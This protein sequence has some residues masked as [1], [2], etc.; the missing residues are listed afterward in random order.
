MGAFSLVLGRHHRNSDTSDL[1]YSYLL[2]NS[3]ESYLV[4]AINL[5]SVG[6]TRDA[7]KW[8]IR[9]RRKGPK[10]LDHII[11]NL[12]SPYSVQKIIKGIDILNHLKKSA[13]NANGFYT[14]NGV[15]IEEKSLVRGLELYKLGLIKF[16]GNG[17]LKKLEVGNYA[18]EEEMRKALS[19]SA[20][21]GEQSWV[22]MAGLIVPKEKVNQL[23]MSI[24]SGEVSDLG[25]LNSFFSTWKDHYFDW[26]WNWT[27]ARL[28]SEIQLD[29]QTVKV[30]EIIAFVKEWESAVVGLDKMMYEDARK[31]FTLKSQTGFG[32]DGS[33]DT[34]ALDF[35][36]VRGGF[37]S[38]PDVVGILKHIDKKTKLANFVISK[39]E[40][41]MENSSSVNIA[42]N[43]I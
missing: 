42:S 18:T 12:L 6:T 17:L 10:H 30:P 14:Y 36:N 2:E 3:D 7:R 31:E 26:V 43:E 41:V 9:D 11:F 38:H 20:L 32:I 25:T 1:P 4:P 24:E 34:K 21:N 15:R 29:L 27:V 8:P 23:I 5:R 19:S 33:N 28:Q 37:S 40:N 22:D 39:L 16:L 13:E 35:E